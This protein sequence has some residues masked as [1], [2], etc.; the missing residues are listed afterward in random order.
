MINI[1]MTGQQIKNVLEDAM[2]Y[3]IDPAGSY[4]AYPRSSGLRFDIN[5]AMDKGS[6]VNN[7]EVNSRLEGEWVEM[8]MSKTYSLT[9]N[10][11]L[12]DGKDGYGEFANIDRSLMVDTF[13][14]YAQSFIEYAEKAGTLTKVSPDRASTQTWTDVRVTEEDPTSSAALRFERTT[15]I[16]YAVGLFASMQMLSMFL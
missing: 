15:L 16:I 3:Y 10:N 7:I 13:V 2:D 12:A 4:G 14:E 1:Q 9:T 11:F 8:D 6:R 5:E